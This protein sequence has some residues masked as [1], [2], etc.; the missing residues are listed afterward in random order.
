ME[1]LEQSEKVSLAVKGMTCNHCASTVNGIIQQEGGKE[2][3]VDYLMGEAHFDLKD[4]QKIDRILKRLKDAGYESKAELNENEHDHSEGMG[5]I[6]KKFLAT[7]PFSLV[8]FSHMFL[9]HDWLIN[10][11]WVQLALCVPVYLI[12]LWHFGKS[13]LESI[14]SRNLNMDVLIL[15]GSSSA[16]FYS[17][18][19]AFVHG[20]SP[21]AHNYL[22]F[23]TTSTIITLVLL[24]YVIEHRAVQK[25]TTVLRDLFKA[26]PEKAKKL[27]KNGLNQDLVVV[28]A[29]ELEK[30]DMILVNTGDRVPADGSILYGEI[31]LDESML[32]G[33]SEPVTKKKGQEIFS[34]S[35]VLNGNGTITVEKTGSESTIGQ[36]IELIKQ[37]RADKPSVQKLADRISSVFVP[38]IIGIAILTFALNYFFAE[39]GISTAIIRSVAVMVIACPCAMGLAT[40]TAVSVGLGLAG[41]IGIIIKKASSFEELNAV[42]H[43]IFDKTGTLTEGKIELAL[44]EMDE[45]E[46]QE[47]VWQIIKT[48]EERSSHPIAEA[49]KNVTEHLATVDL[50]N[51]EEVKGQGMKALL[52]REEVKF[53]TASFTN[54]TQAGDLF[55]SRNGKITTVF[56]VRDQIKKEAKSVIKALQADGK[57]VSILS[58]DNE[59]KTKSVAAELGIQDFHAHQ[60]PDQKL[61]FI[62]KSKQRDHVAMVGDGIN[63]SPSLAAADVG[64]SMGTANALAAESAKVVILGS[65]LNQFSILLKI[66][67]K[68]VQTIK[69][70]LFWAF[71][72]NLVAIPLAAM[73]YLDPMLAALSMAFSDVIVI[74]NSLRLRLILPKHIR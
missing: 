14:K 58:G 43:F 35:I 26:K 70:N 73:G 28:K 25:T 30:G 55:F 45:N 7:L 20:E 1:D 12:G 8:L 51:I 13:T 11:I 34:G 17:L 22:F 16:F 23:E 21:D 61:E 24:G 38:T 68:V 53:G 46:D 33:E 36:I 66:S 3:H 67:K 47:Q 5:S 29:T 44:L 19:G 71:A 9:P 2:I 10:N 37:S 56:G 60:L 54:A 62:K 40:P 27:V 41:K 65:S 15:V 32:T 69:Q 74:G 64:I 59:S 18:Y 39:S 50:D 72:Y 6:E 63:D 48:L 42:N 49:V 57:N 52:N 31:Q 4:Q